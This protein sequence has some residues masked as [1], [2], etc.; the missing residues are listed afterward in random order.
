[1]ENDLSY[2]FDGQN[3]YEIEENA[4]DLNENEDRD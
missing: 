3:F 1:M 4:N 2:Y